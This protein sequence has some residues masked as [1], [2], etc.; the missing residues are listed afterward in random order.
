[1]DK[2]TVLLAYVLCGFGGIGL[3]LLIVWAWRF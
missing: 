3:G 2:Y 1:M